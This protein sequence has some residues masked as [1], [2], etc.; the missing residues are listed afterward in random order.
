MTL[1]IY[2]TGDNCQCCQKLIA[3]LDANGINYDIVDVTKL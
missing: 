2:T 1:Q 3:W